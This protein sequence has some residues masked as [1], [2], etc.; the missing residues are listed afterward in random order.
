[1][2]EIVLLDHDSI[3]PQ[4]AIGRGARIFCNESY[5]VLKKQE[6]VGKKASYDVYWANGRPG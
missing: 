1:M 4:T 3:P 6:V 2:L 5:R